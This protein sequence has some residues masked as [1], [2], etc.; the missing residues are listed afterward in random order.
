MHNAKG[1][2]SVL[3]TSQQAASV[4]RWL[5]RLAL[6]QRMRSFTPASL[7]HSSALRLVA[8][9]WEPS[10]DAVNEAVSGMLQA[11]MAAQ[12]VGRGRHAWQ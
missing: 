1:N 8:A 4:P 5:C 6:V 10:Q 12:S 9:W 3:F 2:P 11:L 7:I